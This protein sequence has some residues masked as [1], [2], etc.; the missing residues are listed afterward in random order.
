MEKL[1]RKNEQGMQGEPS[2][3]NADKARMEKRG[4]EGR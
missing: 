3:C 2:D 4:E 1:V